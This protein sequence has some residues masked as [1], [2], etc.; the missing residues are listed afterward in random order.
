VST[1]N[2]FRR[3]LVVGCGQSGTAAAELLVAAGCEVTLYDRRPDV[4]G[5]PT[6]LDGC[7]RAFGREMASDD[8]FE[9]IDLLVLSPGVPPAA[10]RERHRMLVPEAELHG[11]LSLALAVVAG[12]WQGGVELPTVLITGTNGKSTVTALTGAMLA[13]DGRTPF[14]G[15]NLGT[16]LC[17]LVLAV[18]EGR[19]PQPGALVLECSSYQLETTRVAPEAPMTTVAMILN[20]TPDHLDRYASI[21]EYATTKTRIFD[22]LSAHSLALLSAKDPFTPTLQERVPAVCRHALVDGDEP[23]RILESGA[24]ALL[25]HEFYARESLPLAGRHNA[26]NALFALAAARHVGVS[27][28]VC[29]R[30]LAQ[31]EPLPH[32]MNPVADRNG[33]RW[34]NDSKATNVASV[35]AG[36]DGFERPFVLIC[37]GRAKQGDD[38]G[39]LREVLSRQ[40]RGVIAIGESAEAFVQ[41]ADGIVPWARA[42]DM[43]E[44]VHIASEMARSG[45]AVLLSPACA[46]WDMFRN[47]AHRGETFAAAVLALGE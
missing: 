43:P 41:M 9:R 37:G 39:A 26:V 46:S 36:L 8:V 10:W 15:G 18:A 5:L 27:R 1:L 11:E 14:V 24:L 45:D 20:V 44:A 25:E 4:P 3:A 6:R 29:E 30:A 33:V 28:E 31:F 13:A 40:G 17:E 7:A 19:S 34:Y 21:D 42:S 12:D 32:R 23:P 22:G 2:R 47:F 16:P 38:I 35:L